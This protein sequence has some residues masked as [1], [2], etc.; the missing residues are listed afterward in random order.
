MATMETGHSEAGSH[1]HYLTYFGDLPFGTAAVLTTFP[2]LQYLQDLFI[3]QYEYKALFVLFF[4]NISFK[5]IA[6]S[7]Y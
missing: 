1:W 3:F 5:Y 2:Q 4:G 6:F 7:F